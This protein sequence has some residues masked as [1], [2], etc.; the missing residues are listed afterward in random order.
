MRTCAAAAICA[1]TVVTQLSCTT[2]RS[3]AVPT[4]SVAP[5][6]TDA[7]RVLLVV[8]HQD[9][10]AFIVSR[11]RWHLQHGA[12]VWI[13][14]TASSEP[15]GEAYSERRIA[16]ARRAADFLGIPLEQLEF[17]RHPDGL[18]HTELQAILDEIARFIAEIEPDVIY[19][20]AYEMGHIDHDI[21]HFATVYA[22]E[23]SGTD[24]RLIEF[25][26]Y[27]TYRTSWPLPYKLRRWPDTLSTS[28][29]ELSD[30]EFDFVMA[31]WDI[32][33]SQHFPFG[34]YL[35]ATSSLRRVFGTE[36][37]RE[38]PGY[39]YDQ[40]PF[41]A[42]AAYERFLKGVELG[43]LT[44]AVREVCTTDPVENACAGMTTSRGGLQQ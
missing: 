41:E 13:V 7:S 37:T 10:D 11:L 5:D 27:S 32:Y 44:A 34:T 29:R 16:E 39:T 20:P 18:T 28:A 25:P 40:P 31:Y 36:Y 30:T 33:R 12:D 42:P 35:S 21:A 3:T 24:A 26:L 14:W 19:V 22:A 9:D 1:L 8:A 4:G 6:L 38:L 17:L 43:D 23:A 2:A 15:F